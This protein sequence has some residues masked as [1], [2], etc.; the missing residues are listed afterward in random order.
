MFREMFE[1][2]V[3]D[4]PPKTLLHCSQV[5]V[6]TEFFTAGL[7]Y[8]AW[9]LKILGQPKARQAAQFFMVSTVVDKSSSSL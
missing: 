7:V 3:S 8:F 5:R 1:A 6:V 2:A 4:S 9:F